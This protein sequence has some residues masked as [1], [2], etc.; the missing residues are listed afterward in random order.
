M[1]SVTHDG[2]SVPARSGILTVRPLLRDMRVICIRILA[3]SQACFFA[4]TKG[5]ARMAAG[6]Y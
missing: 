4:E 3:A 5:L 6:A 1:A 2:T